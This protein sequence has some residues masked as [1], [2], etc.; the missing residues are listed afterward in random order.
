MNFICNKD[1]CKTTKEIPEE[2]E[3]FFNQW[4]MEIE[5]RTKKRKAAG[6][7]TPERA[8]CNCPACGGFSD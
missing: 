8:I 6:C 1:G 4:D 7:W 3:S 5:E 2:L